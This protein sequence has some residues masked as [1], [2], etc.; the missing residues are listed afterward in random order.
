MLAIVLLYLR[1]YIQVSV[2]VGLLFL[3]QNRIL[4][5]QKKEK[6]MRKNN[7]CSIEVPP[8]LPENVN[9]NIIA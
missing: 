7:L 2:R 8:P 6:T 3:I 1:K 9:P 4:K 5:G